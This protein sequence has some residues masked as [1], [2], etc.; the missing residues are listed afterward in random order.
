[1]FAASRITVTFSLFVFK[2]LFNNARRSTAVV[3][4]HDRQD[5]YTSVTVR[6]SKRETQQ[7]SSDTSGPREIP[8]EIVQPL[9]G[10]MVVGKNS[11]KNNVLGGDVAVSARSLA[12]YGALFTTTAGTS[13]RR[14]AR[15]E[16]V[17]CPAARKA[18]E[19]TLRCLE[20]RNFCVC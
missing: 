7:I 16:F 19:S 1:M 12:G 17:A 10:V 5:S 13:L 20:L 14:R 15:G 11:E 9:P 3:G 2:E 6:P 8:R 18:E 4:P